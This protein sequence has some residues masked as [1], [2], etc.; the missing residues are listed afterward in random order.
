MS[1]PAALYV[2][3]TW[4]RRFEPR[5]HAFRYRVFQLL[6]DVDRIEAAA[7]GLRLLRVGRFG[8][9]SIHPGDHGDRS[10][11][12]LRGWVEQ[13]L[14]EAGMDCEAATIRLLAF[15]RVL[16]FTFN[17]LSIF[18]VHD[19]SGDLE[20]IIYEVNNTF[21]QTHAYVVP[22]GPGRRQVQRAA[23]RFYVSPFYRVEGEYRF[24]VAPPEERFELRIV[25]ARSGRPDFV[26]TQQAARVALTDRALLRLFLGMPL[27]TIKVVAAIHW[28]AL[29]LWIKGAPFGAQPPTP[30]HGWSAGEALG[31][32]KREN[33]DSL[34]AEDRSE[35][36]RFRR[37]RRPVRVGNA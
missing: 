8:L 5:V 9:F 16:G 25:K 18:F 26:A 30:P 15:P 32:A 36:E 22:A 12:P 10:G 20:A 35:H 13:R 14:S 28:E 27:M 34:I 6:L 33:G 29:R 3:D 31:L 17:P 24:D 1:D 4:H 23:K 37:K 21:G 7:S 2:G 11:A 19:G